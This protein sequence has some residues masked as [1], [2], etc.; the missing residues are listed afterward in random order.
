MI[1]DYQFGLSYYRLL[2][3]RK[4][5]SDRKIKDIQTAL[6]RAGYRPGP[7]DGKFGPKTLRAVEQFQRNQGL[8]VDG[9]VGSMTWRKLQHFL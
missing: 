9:V 7:I 8:K 4:I 6:R 5:W 1:L 2:Q 3:N